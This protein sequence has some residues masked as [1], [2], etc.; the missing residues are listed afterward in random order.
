VPLIRLKHRIALG[1]VVLQLLLAGL[2][3]LS[4]VF[5]DRAAQGTAELHRHAYTTSH[6]LGE[7]RNRVFEIKSVLTHNIAFPGQ[8]HPNDWVAE[9]K[10]H[11]GIIEQN[12][13]V[14]SAND[15]SSGVDIQAVQTA[16]PPLRAFINQNVDAI[17]SGTIDTSH[18]A[19]HRGNWLF[20]HVVET[21][22]DAMIAANAQAS[23]RVGISEDL[24][25]RLRET[26]IIVIAAALILGGIVS[27][28]LTLAITAPLARL[29]AAMLH[30]N[31]GD[32]DTIIPDTDRG[33]EIGDIARTLEHLKQEAWEKRR[34]QLKFATIFDAS[35]DIV[36]I[37]ERDTG[38][39]LDV[40]GGF[41]SYL[42]HKR[43]DVIGR[44]S[45]D[46]GIWAS[47]DDRAALVLALMQ[48]GRLTNFQSRA[49]R[50]DG[51][52]F[53]ALV[54]AEQFRLDDKD[55]M[56]FVARD[57]TVFK[58]QEELLRRS[59]TELERSNRELERFAHVAAHDLQEPCRTICSFSQLLARS[60]GSALSSEGREY[61]NFLSQGAIRM[62]EQIQG[63]LDYSSIATTP[64]PFQSIDLNQLL[65]WVLGELRAN[66][67]Q[68]NASIHRTSLP[69]VRGDPVQ[70]R[71][72]F[73]NLISN[74]LKF[75]PRG[76]RAELSIAA[77]AA[78]DFWKITIADNGIGIDAPF[79]DGVF[80]L[81]RRLH[82]PEQYPGSGLGLTI[83][84]RIVERHG[85]TIGLESRLG[86]GT[87]VSFTL[88]ACPDVPGDNA[89]CDNKVAH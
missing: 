84:K 3:A 15:D 8:A 20:D 30:V 88:P 31:E 21:I 61:L 65:D 87:T 41:E 14:A 32:P 75:Q 29:R 70:L 33:D 62:R 79:Q 64:A 11:Q 52:I 66:L 82:G 45:F 2:G 78:Q 63:L 55:C 51:E 37:S 28:A 67:A 23:E 53:D 44:S 18:Q 34:T 7:V 81:F 39:F 86:H 9:V 42:G 69:V 85:G 36:T 56:I 6:A 68:H 47:P 40:N 60:D 43:E 72:L 71:Q 46:V 73:S 48:Q 74:G 76:N 1:F 49:K 4:V 25:H 57:I 80:D 35:P 59:L 89:H 50:K 16:W 26:V 12:L 38:C 27:T 54:S 22:A 83:A 58:Q 13:A 10:R 24:R 5:I 17:N 19:F 77:I